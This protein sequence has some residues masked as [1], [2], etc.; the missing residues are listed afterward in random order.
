MLISQSKL[1]LSCSLQVPK[2]C[3][4]GQNSQA[5]QPTEGQGLLYDLWSHFHLS[6]DRGE[7]SFGLF[8]GGF[9]SVRL[10]SQSLLAFWTRITASNQKLTKF[11][12]QLDWRRSFPPRNVPGTAV[13]LP[14]LHSSRRNRH[15]SK[16]SCLSNT[17]FSIQM[18]L[19]AKD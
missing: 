14:R 7:Y 19:E 9:W 17:S 4:I 2:A 1:F 8:N 10:V 13:I 3:K 12:A 6:A 16:I 18:L 5:P 15:L 11:F